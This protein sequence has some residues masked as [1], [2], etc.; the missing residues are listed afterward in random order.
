MNVTSDL[1]IR[2]GANTKSTEGARR[3]ARS[4][5]NNIKRTV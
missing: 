1:A 3:D 2:C 4:G 5:R